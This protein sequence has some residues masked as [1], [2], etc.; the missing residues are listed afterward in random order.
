[1]DWNNDGLH[2]LL[3]GDGSGYVHI[4]LNTG[5][6]T[7]PVL[8]GGTIIQSGAEDIDVGIRAAPIVDD[9]NGD[10]RK[11]LLVGNFDGNILVYLN[12]GTD[13][14]PVFNS[15]FNLQAGGEDFDIGSRAAPRIFDWDQDGL[16]DL[17]VGEVEGYIYFMKNIGNSDAPVFN[18]YERLLKAGGE[19]LQYPDPGGNPRSRLY[20]TDWDNNGN[21]DILLG[22]RE[23]K[24]LLYI[25]N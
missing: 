20:V 15:S 24:V 2:D 25:A 19:P 21:F 16:K 6:N 14:S 23:G 13:A 8:D 18:A 10:G 5:S 1:V 22:G 3:V 17:L 11:D 7:V 12:E 4:Y 9:W